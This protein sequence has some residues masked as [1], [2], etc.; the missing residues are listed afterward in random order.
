MEQFSTTN[1]VIVKHLSISVEW[2]LILQNFFDSSNCVKLSSFLLTLFT[3]NKNLKVQLSNSW[4]IVKIIFRFFKMMNEIFEIF[5]IFE[6]GFYFY[7]DWS[8]GWSLTDEIRNWIF[9][10]RNVEKCLDVSY[11][12]LI[13][14]VSFCWDMSFLMIVDTKVIVGRAFWTNQNQNRLFHLDWKRCFCCTCSINI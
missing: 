6:I 8:V 2:T 5:E 7:R 10:V 11:F 3:Y 14:D 9:L 13:V 4:S 12:L 1:Q